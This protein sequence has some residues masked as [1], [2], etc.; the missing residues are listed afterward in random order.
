MKAYE[1]LIVCVSLPE[2]TVAL[3]IANN[4][5]YCQQV[6]TLNRTRTCIYKKVYT[7]IQV[8]HLAVRFTALPSTLDDIDIARV[9]AKWGYARSVYSRL[10]AHRAFRFNLANDFD[11]GDAP[12]PSAVQ[13][14][15]YLLQWLDYINQVMKLAHPVKFLLEPKLKIASSCLS[16]R[17]YLTALHKTFRK[18]SLKT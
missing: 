12:K 8:Q 10:S 13:H 4:S 16:R 7:Y 2:E 14:I 6:V 5:K 3:A 9:T 11:W 18:I 17:L 1:G 15:E